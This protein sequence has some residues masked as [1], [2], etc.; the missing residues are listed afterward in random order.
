MKMP[1]MTSLSDK[2]AKAVNRRQALGVNPHQKQQ[3]PR[4]GPNRNDMEHGGLWSRLN[5][6]MT[7]FQSIEGGTGNAERKRNMMKSTEQEYRRNAPVVGSAS[8][9][10]FSSAKQGR[11]GGDWGETHPPLK[12]GGVFPQKPPP[13]PMPSDRAAA[14]AEWVRETLPTCA[15]VAAEFR[16]SFGD[17]RLVYAREAGHEIG[18]RS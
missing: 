5:G 17:V 9:G 4:G 12:G 2:S 18:R 13:Q 1:E 15:A 7:G 16:E 8:D 11:Q 3:Q 10:F 6:V 14:M